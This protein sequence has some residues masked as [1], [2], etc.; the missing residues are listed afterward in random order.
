MELYGLIISVVISNG[1]NGLI[2]IQGKWN[3]TQF[4]RTA[5]G[6]SVGNE[7]F[8]QTGEGCVCG[9]DRDAWLECERILNEIMVREGLCGENCRCLHDNV[10]VVDGFV[11]D[12]QICDVRYAALEHCQIFVGCC[13]EFQDIMLRERIQEDGLNFG[14]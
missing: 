1:I 9:A 3:T 10:I 7:E 6:H 4:A 13:K 14:R 2:V 8:S 5:A 12:G 11:K